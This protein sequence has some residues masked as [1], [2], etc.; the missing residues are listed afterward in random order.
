MQCATH[1]QIETHIRC[2]RCDKAICYRCMVETPVGHRCRECAQIR[3]L[4][5]LTLSPVQLLQSIGAAIAL[6]F[7]GGIVWA[8]AHRLNFGFVLVIAA[9]GI[10][11][12]VSEGISRAANR[13]RAASLPV[14]A[15][16]SAALSF[17][18]GNALFFL[19]WTS[20]SFSFALRHMADIDLFGIWGLL[21]AILAVGV[22]VSRLR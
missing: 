7:G 8:I 16:A 2:S 19:F 15:G 20:A 18:I 13:K 11:Y 4:P 3:R 17:F 9:V 1:P 14:M 22:A 10:G 5:V 12:V 6:A 21:S